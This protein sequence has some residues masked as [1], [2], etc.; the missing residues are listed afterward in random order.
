MMRIMK[1]LVALATIKRFIAVL[2]LNILLRF[3]VMPWF[4]QRFMPDG[5]PGPLDLKFAYTAS[6]AAAQIARFDDAGRLGYRLF[7]LTV[8]IVYPVAYGL[9]L[10]WAIALLKQRTRW[11][12]SLLP[13]IPAV[14]AFACDIL[15]NLTVSTLL[16]I[17]PLQ[18]DMIGWMASIFTTL[19]WTFVAVS[20]VEIFTL[21]FIRLRGRFFENPPSDP[22]S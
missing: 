22:I 21:G 16:T 1:R 13:V 10:V 6:E 15:E 20:I 17:Y 12:K 5:S 2:A 7:L 18:P 14:A 19:K 9:A 8:D 4:H 3:A 11:E